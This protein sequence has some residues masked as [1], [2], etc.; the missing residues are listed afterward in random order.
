M[1]YKRAI[2]TMCS[3]SNS[4]S[5]EA[6]SYQRLLEKKAALY[7]KMEEIEQNTHI[8]EC[9]DNYIDRIQTLHKDCKSNYDWEK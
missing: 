2:R 3:L 6:S 4:L 8:V 5:R 7:E 1:G 9:F